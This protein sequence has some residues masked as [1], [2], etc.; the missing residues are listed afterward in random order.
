MGKARIGPNRTSDKENGDW[1][2]E[3]ESQRVWEGHGHAPD[4][5][6]TRK[7][8]AGPVANGVLDKGHLVF[9][10]Y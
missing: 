6:K 1:I 5:L 3:N 2:V 8:F 4:P 9:S 10:L 7:K